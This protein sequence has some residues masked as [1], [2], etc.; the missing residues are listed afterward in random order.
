MNQPL[1]DSLEVDTQSSLYLQPQ[2]DLKETRQGEPSSHPCSLSL[3][4]ETLGHCCN[5]GQLG[6][7]LGMQKAGGVLKLTLTL[8]SAGAKRQ[9]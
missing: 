1:G 8:K 5:S 4:L 7:P 6:G 9:S 2:V 3:S